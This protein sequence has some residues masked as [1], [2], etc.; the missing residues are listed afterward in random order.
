MLGGRGLGL[1]WVR[2][3]GRSL[4]SPVIVKFLREW[5][6]NFLSDGLPHGVGLKL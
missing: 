6:L 2:F 5:D 3:I 1:L 4:G